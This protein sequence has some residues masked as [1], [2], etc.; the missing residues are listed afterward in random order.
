MVIVPRRNA[1]NPSPVGGGTKKNH[2]QHHELF[3][4]DC[5]FARMARCRVIMSFMRVH[6]FGV[7]A[8][9][10]L[11]Q[12]TEA[13]SPTIQLSVGWS[14]VDITPRIAPDAPPVWMAGYGHNRRA[15]GVHDPLFARVL[16][17]GAGK[18]R[19][20]IVGVDLIGLMRPAILAIRREL[21]DFDAVWIVSTHNHQGPD[22]IGLWGPS[23]AVSGVSEEY[24]R[25][26]VNQIARA[27]RQA[28]SQAAACVADFGSADDASL[29]KDSRLP[30]VLDPTLRVV[31]FSTPDRSRTLGLLVQWNCH[32]ESM[33]SANTRITADFPGATIAALAARHRAPVVYVNGAVGGLM[34]P[35]GGRF[36]DP[37]GLPYVEGR[38][39]WMDHY[40]KRVAD[41]ADRAIADARPIS[42]APIA[43]ASIPIRL[44]VANPAYQ[45]LHTMGVLKR[46]LFPARNGQPPGIE[47]EVACLRLGQLHLAGIPG[48]L[49]PELVH[50]QYQEPVDPAADLPDAPL[51]TPVMNILPRGPR[52]L[53]GLANDEIGY[54]IPKRQWDAAPPYCYGRKSMQYGE[55][56]SVGPEAAPLLMQALKQAVESAR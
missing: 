39:D 22:V 55:I 51:E 45:L 41:L 21:A 16:A 10:L 9:C 19:V 36:K 15:A 32:P 37:K 6:P 4:F 43:H 20:A 38:W 40:G 50:G 11:I 47:T 3:S 52:M 33:G 49:Y 48:E 34:A 54:I 28:G 13:Q 18:Q 27:V 26:I 14:A 24:I 12:R 30:V 17:L 29:L 31:R 7:L 35:P 1:D 53:L 25:I 46:D 8:L 23:P 56:N 42:L 2:P 5:R 44:P